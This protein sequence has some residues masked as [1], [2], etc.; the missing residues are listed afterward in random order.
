MKSALANIG[1]R[2]K[3]EQAAALEKAGL[4]GNTEFIAANT[5]AFIKTLETL[6]KELSPAET[7]AENAN[8]TEDTAYLKEQLQIIKTACEN[9]DDTA[10]YAAFDRL[11]EKTW[12][13]E[14]AQTLEKIRDVLFLDSDFDSVAEQVEAIL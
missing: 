11:K 1:E 12:K 7:V 2:E 5:E 9:Y 6:V 8:V 3:S 13:P 10:A 14:T 4:D